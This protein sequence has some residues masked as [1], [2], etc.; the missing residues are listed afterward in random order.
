MVIRKR[1]NMRQ[2][3]LVCFQNEIVL[4]QYLSSRSFPAK[5]THSRMKRQRLDVKGHGKSLPSLRLKT[6][7][8]SGKRKDFNH[9]NN[10][11]YSEI[12]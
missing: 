5:S 11:Y 7:S 8:K 1:S 3:I 12:I 10:F 2:K 4:Q 6:C 9:S